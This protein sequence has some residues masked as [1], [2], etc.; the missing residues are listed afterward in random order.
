MYD[1]EVRFERY[2]P[3]DDAAPVTDVEGP[4]PVDV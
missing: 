2:K 3:G 4:V 1:C